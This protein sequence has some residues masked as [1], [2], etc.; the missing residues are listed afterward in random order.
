MEA[1]L[2]LRLA[3]R[4]ARPRFRDAFAFA[5][6]DTWAALDVGLTYRIVSRMR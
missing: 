5:A 2:V 4:L 1:S 3:L 6:L